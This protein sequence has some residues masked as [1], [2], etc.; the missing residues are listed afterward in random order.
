MK[1]TVVAFLLAFIMVLGLGTACAY[2]ETP[3]EPAS[4]DG[5]VLFEKDGVKV[6]TAGLD[7][8]PTEEDSPIIWLD[9]ENTGDQDAFLGIAN[10]SVNGFMSDV[11]F[12]DYYIED[13]E[14]RGGDYTFS[15]TL[16]AG[17]SHRYG[18]GYYKNGAPGAGFDTL[19]EMEL[20]FTLAEDEYSWPNYTSEPVVIVTGETVEDVD[21]ASLGTVVLDDEKLTLVIG[22]QDYDDFFGPMVYVYA[23]NKSDRF[24]GLAADSA[25]ADGVGCDYIFYGQTLAPGKKAAAFMCFDGEMQKLRGFENLT[26]SFSLREAATGDEL[27]AMFD[28]AALDPVSVQY[29]PQVWGEYENDGLTLEVRP[30]YN[31][32]ITVETPADDANGILFSVSETASLEAGGFDGAGWL[33]SIGKLGADRLHELLR[34]DM[35]GAYVI[36]KDGD[37]AYYMLYH[38]TDVRYARETVEE[39][40]RDQAQ[41]SMLCEWAGTAADSFVEKNGL[42][43]ASFGNSEVDMLVADAAWGENQELT[44]STTEFGPVSAS[45]ADGT[46]AAEFVLQGGFFETDPDE[47][48]DGQYVVLNFPEQE[49]RLDF[50]FAPGNYARIVSGDR[51]TLYQAMMYGEE[52]SCAEAMQRWYYAALEQAGVRSPKLTLARMTTE[53]KIAQ[54]LMPAF[55]SYPD[56]NGAQQKLTEMRP[57]IEEMLKRHG[58]AGVIFFAENMTDTE[59]AVRLTDAMQS[60]NAAAAGRPQLLTA[61]DQEGGPVVRLGHGCQMPGN[62]ALGAIGDPAAAEQAGKLIGEEISAVGINYDAAPVVD[63]NVNPQNPV[64]GLRSFSDDPAL[65]AEMG[66][67][68]MRGLRSAGVISTL[69]H[70]PGHGDTATDSH[71]GLPRIEKSLEELK[72][73]ELIP[74]QACIDAG[75]EAIMTAHIQYPLI[76]KKTAVSVETGEKINLPAT[77]SKTILTDLLRGEMGFDGVI[78]SDA[79]NMDAIAKHFEPLAVAQMAIEAG[80]N[81]I[82]MPVDTSTPEG[83][84]ALDAYISDLAALVDEGTIPLERVDDSVLRVLRLKEAHGLLTSYDGGDLDGRVARALETVGSEEHHA[85]EAELAARALTLVKN[86]NQ[87]LPL[88]IAEEK[89][90]ILVPFDSEVQ[91]AE[92][93]VETLKSEE[94]LPETADIQAVS[95]SAFSKADLE[96]VKHLVAVSAIYGAREMDPWTKDG[97]YSLLLDK[98]IAAVHEAGGDVTIVSAQL[99]YDAERYRDADAVVI[100]WYAKGMTEDIRTLEETPLSYGVNLPAALMQILNAEGVFPGKLPVKLPDVDADGQFAEEALTPAA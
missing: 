10:G 84:A 24:L 93:A 62:M 83:L 7:V 6:T 65:V 19:G 18:L 71:T 56:E 39:M 67:A 85:I 64:I 13:G 11:V 70:F 45:L 53:E 98:V 61:I 35:S 81:I 72:A 28:G 86:E 99:P 12:I 1:K 3:T 95:Y 30:K 91:S 87:L 97:A 38:P 82:L 21:I 9:I 37:G 51:E 4:P 36:A 75:A 63:V 100:A 80:V 14:Y 41:W 69:K 66:T 46:A 47:T 96:N 23:E 2:A 22:G 73:L 59:Q 43:P 44:L 50:F 68:L 57:E 74:F 76:E 90:L 77:L 15:I 31:E 88:R 49:L 60:A 33:F 55:R 32:L 34:Y 92:Y 27:D 17:S 26:L 52:E 25:S 94:K 42:E 20:C 8:D 58:F 89:T 78:I 48:P 16:Q 40:Y 79:M 5:S 29:P 54:M